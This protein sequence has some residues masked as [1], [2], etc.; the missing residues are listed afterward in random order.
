LLR[1]IVPTQN[2]KVYDF[3]YELSYAIICKLNNYRKRKLLKPKEKAVEHSE[4]AFEKVV[5][6]K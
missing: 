4:N 1:T 5:R 3:E 2:C 6:V